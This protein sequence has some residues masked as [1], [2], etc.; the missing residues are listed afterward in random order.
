M[1]T[2][3]II[4]A[5]LLTVAATAAC[6]GSPTAPVLEAGSTTVRMDGTGFLGGGTMQP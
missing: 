5:L 2:L 6:T 4:A 3:R 1:K